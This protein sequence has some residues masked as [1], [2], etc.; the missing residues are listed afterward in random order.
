VGTSVQ[1][2]SN[3]AGTATFTLYP[4]GSTSTATANTKIT[5]TDALNCSQSSPN[6]IAVNV[7]AGTLSLS[8]SSL[9]F[10]ALGSSNNQVFTAQDYNYIGTLSASSSNTG[11]A[12]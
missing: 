12:T 7:S 2:T 3:P 6:S 1:T 8:A 5:F 9:S 11:V 4:V 10:S